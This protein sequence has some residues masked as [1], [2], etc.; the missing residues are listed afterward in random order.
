MSLLLLVFGV[1][2]ALQAQLAAANLMRAVREQNT[3]SAE[4][5]ACMEQLLLLSSDAIPR[6]GGPYAAG[7]PITAFNDRNLSGERIVATYPGFVGGTPPDPLEILL[8][9]TWND[10]R[11]RPQRMS[12]TT[13]KTR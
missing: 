4:L 6:A 5:E 9:L 3:A 8:T 13:M 2:S 7:Q 10:W 12:L 11:G 1:L